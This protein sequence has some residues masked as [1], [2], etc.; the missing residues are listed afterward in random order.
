MFL[1]INPGRNLPPSHHSM[2]EMLSF[3][4]YDWK[5]HIIIPIL[6][7]GKDP[8]SALNYRP[9]AISSTLSKVMEHLVKNRLE[10][11]LE[12]RGILSRTQFGFRKGFSTMDSLSILVS[13]IRLAFS[14][15]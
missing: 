6:K 3:W 1:F 9:I 15:N 8:S 11:I 14:K 7:P 12:N 4:T 5:T 2:Y 13:D 10:W